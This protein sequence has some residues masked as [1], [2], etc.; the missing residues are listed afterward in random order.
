LFYF[1]IPNVTV[2]VSKYLIYFRKTKRSCENPLGPFTANENNSSAYKICKLVM[3][4]R[5]T[6]NVINKI[7]YF[8][9]TFQAEKS[10]VDVPVFDEIENFFY[11]YF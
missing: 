1:P 11:K 9:I 3:Y 4:C 8:N 7:L 10:F 6:D 2:S 5:N